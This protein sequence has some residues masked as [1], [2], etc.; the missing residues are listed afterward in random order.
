[1]LVQLVGRLVSG[2]VFAERLNVEPNKS[3]QRFE[4]ANKKGMQGAKK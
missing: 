3:N 1:M 4:L 2:Y